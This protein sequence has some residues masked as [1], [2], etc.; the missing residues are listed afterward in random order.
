MSQKKNKIHKLTTFQ[1]S[2]YHKTPS[3]HFGR[4]FWIPCSRR[5]QPLMLHLIFVFFGCCCKCPRSCRSDQPHQQQTSFNYC[6][7]FWN[8]SKLIVTNEIKILSIFNIFL[9]IFNHQR[10]CCN[11]IHRWWWR[12]RLSLSL[13]CDSMWLM[14]N[15]KELSVN[16]LKSSLPN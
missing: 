8:L 3:C 16:V 1:V 2:D 10:W 15:W 7:A 11:H 9:Y 14:F 13:N 4:Y 6:V 5:R 12:R